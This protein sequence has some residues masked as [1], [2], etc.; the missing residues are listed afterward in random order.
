MTLEE[1][2]KIWYMEYSHRSIARFTGLVGFLPFFYFWI[3][4][5]LPVA[6]VLKALGLNSLILGQVR[7]NFLQF[8]I[9]LYDLINK[10][11]FI[12]SSI[13]RDFLVGTWSRVA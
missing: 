3:R 7:I 11:D 9:C 8:F 6:I 2:K 12:C 13:D 4:N 1:F 10:Y 5:E